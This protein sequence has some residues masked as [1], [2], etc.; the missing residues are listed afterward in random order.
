MN[1]TRSKL[2]GIQKNYETLSQGRHPQMLL[3]RVQSEHPP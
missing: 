3:S 1:Y 2:R